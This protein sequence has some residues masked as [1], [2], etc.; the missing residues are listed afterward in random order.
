MDASSSSKIKKHWLYYGII[1]VAVVYNL[2]L[3]TQ[4]QEKTTETTPTQDEFTTSSFTK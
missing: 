2:M 4:P 3:M 1:L